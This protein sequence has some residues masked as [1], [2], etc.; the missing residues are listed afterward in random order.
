MGYF[1]SG[2]SF[3]V[4]LSVDVFSHQQNKEFELPHDKAESSS[5]L[6]IPSITS[7]TVPT[8]SLLMFVS[9]IGVHSLFEGFGVGVTK[10][11][12]SM[13]SVMAALLAHKWL[14]AAAVGVFISKV[15]KNH[16][17]FP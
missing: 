15:S 11:L 9:A 12:D 4:L 7:P 2:I 13:F 17:S 5:L 10:T 8:F 1:I 6:S 14:E 3:L 16:P